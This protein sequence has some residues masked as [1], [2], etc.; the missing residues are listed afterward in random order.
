MTTEPPL[1]TARLAV[2]TAFAALEDLDDRPKEVFALCNA[3]SRA[4]PRLKVDA[5]ASYSRS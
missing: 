4:I 3:L 1:S 5:N 2:A